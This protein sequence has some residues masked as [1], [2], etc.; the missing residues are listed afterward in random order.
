MVQDVPAAR[1][2]PLRLTLDEPAVA[3]MVPPPHEPVRPF[4]VATT[5]PA[6]SVSVKATPVRGVP[7]FGFVS[8]KVSVVVPFSGTVAPPKTLEIA[9][10][11]TADT[12]TEAEA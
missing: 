3:V 7:A 11:V 10:A 5:R 8:V 6:G 2:P 12:T 4:G 9:G 1:V